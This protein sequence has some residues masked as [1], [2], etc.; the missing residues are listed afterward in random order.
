MRKL[1]I[2]IDHLSTV[3]IFYRQQGR[4]VP[5]GNWDFTPPGLR[6]NNVEDTFGQQGSLFQGPIVANGTQAPHAK[7]VR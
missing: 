5:Y 4:F 6:R 2:S 7:G 3:T 1:G